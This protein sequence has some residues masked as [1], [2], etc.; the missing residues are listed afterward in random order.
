MGDDPIQTGGSRADRAGAVLCIS[1]PGRV[2]AHFNAKDT[3]GQVLHAMGFL[4]SVEHWVINRLKAESE[5]MAE[6]VR[7][8]LQRLDD[9][10]NNYRDNIPPDNPA[11]LQI[12]SWLSIDQ[13]T[14]TIECLQSCQPAFLTQL[15]DHCRHNRL[16]DS[17]AELAINRILTLTRARLIDR[18]FGRDNVEYVVKT[19][20]EDA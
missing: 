12:L 4:A 8:R 3:T 16:N 1:D 17:N 18:I 11:F 6:E 14:Y 15:M 20:M 19:L 9:I 7:L 5:E 10:V 2:A 13:A